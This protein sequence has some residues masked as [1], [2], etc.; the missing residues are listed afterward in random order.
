[1]RHIV[2]L[3]AI[4]CKTIQIKSHPQLMIFYSQLLSF[5]KTPN[6]VKKYKTIWAARFLST[7]L[8][9]VCVFLWV[10]SAGGVLGGDLSF[11]Y[12]RMDIVRR[13]LGFGRWF[14]WYEIEFKDKLIQICNLLKLIVTIEWTHTFSP[15]WSLNSFL[16]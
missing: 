8:V 11:P 14:C 4:W 5:R 7:F 16:E 10:Q 1:M 3:S 12:G 2:Y 15:L 9:V 6:I 13:Q